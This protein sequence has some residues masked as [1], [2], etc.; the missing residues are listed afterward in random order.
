MSRKSSLSFGLIVSVLTAT[1][2][3]IGTT[4]MAYAQETTI[5]TAYSQENVTGTQ[6]T[7]GITSNE[8]EDDKNDVEEG[9][10]EDA[11]EPGDIDGPNDKED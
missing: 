1:A 6:N 10:G 8:E 2:L 4:L 11:D 5:Q 3:S 7:T 9:P